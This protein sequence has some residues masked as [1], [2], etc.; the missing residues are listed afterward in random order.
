MGNLNQTL[1]SYIESQIFPRYGGDSSGHG[2]HHIEY[3]IRRSLQFAEKIGNLNMDMVYTIAAFHDIGHPIDKAHHE[4][5][6]AEIF[7][8]DVKMLDFFTDAQRKIIAEAIEDHRA[9]ANHEPRSIYGKIVSTADRSTDIN[10]FLRRTHAYTL[11]HEPNLSRTQC[12]QRAYQHMQEKYGN[13]GYAKSYLPDVAYTK[14]LEKI[15][16]LLQDYD[17]FEV[18]YREVIQI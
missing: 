1:K 6:S 7:L 16:E 2:R 12:V 9:S 4:I 14:F 3:V 10:E 5:I 13:E 17:A 18:Y 11:K 8:E 15:A